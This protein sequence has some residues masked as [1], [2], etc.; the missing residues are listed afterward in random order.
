MA[1]VI[2]A[3][4]PTS[5]ALWRMA[6][7]VLLGF[8]AILIEAAPLG[9]APR[10]LP[11]PDL[12]AL[13]VAIIAVRRPDAIALPVVF[14]LGLTRDLVTDLPIGAGT[15]SLVLSAEA[16][17]LMGVNL[18][19]GSLAREAAVTAA[20]LFGMLAL[21]YLL[22]LMLFVQPPY[23]MSVVRQWVISMT[24]WPLVLI[25]VR[26]GCGIRGAHD[27]STRHRQPRWHASATSE[28]RS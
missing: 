17:R 3:L 20:V 11:S 24:F 4:I 6:L 2:Q 8:L 18:L 19:R 13:T 21:Q 7:L 14:A 16:M 25:V 5:A 15:L 10:S 23:V 27:P 9:I 26:W 28:G 22:T 1:A 12:L